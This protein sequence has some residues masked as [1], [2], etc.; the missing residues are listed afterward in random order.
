MENNSKKNSF[1]SALFFAKEVSGISSG[2]EKNHFLNRFNKFTDGIMKSLAYTSARA[3]GFFFLS[4][5]ILSLIM[6]LAKYYFADNPVVELT[7]LIICAAF[8]LVGVPLIFVDKPLSIML[9]DFI[10][11]D[12]IFF[13][14]F[15]IKRM[16][17]D[18]KIKTIP[19]LV[20]IIVG[21]ILAILA[22]LFGVEFVLLVL[23]LLI[24][25]T[26]SFVSAEFPFLFTL[27]ILPY[28]SLFPNPDLSLLG[29]LI[30]TLISFF[31]KVIL[32]KRVYVFGISD[33]LI[34]LFAFCIFMF[35]VIGGGDI[36]NDKNL[37]YFVFS[38]AYIPTANMIVNRRLADCAVEAVLAS[39]TPVALYS[40]IVHILR[41]SGVDSVSYNAIGSGEAVAALLLVAT[42][43]SLFHIPHKKG[44]Q[45]VV[46][47]IELILYLSS[48]LTSTL[49]PVLIILPIFFIAFAIIFRT[50]T[51][52]VWA[53]FLF[54]VPG[55]IFLLPNSVLSSISGI[56]QMNLTL[57]EMRQQL[58]SLVEIFFENIF[59]GYDYSHDASIIF[60]NTPI[61]IGLRFGI[62]AVVII[63]LILLLRL[64][65]FSLYDS[66]LR[67][68]SSLLRLSNMTFLAMMSLLM[69]GW[70]ND[71]SADLSIYALFSLVFGMSTASLRISK[72][73]YEDRQRYFGDNSRVDSSDA[74]I[75]LKNWY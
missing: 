72:N 14:F 13:E 19:N 5:G 64:R 12:Y 1:L 36:L 35:G 2:R 73:E 65:Q 41:L 66:Y 31:R 15:S 54:L 6:N 53:L 50:R 18:E 30:L 7:T 24:F 71:V 62:F 74:D 61:A 28:T 9:Q 10:I 21:L 8:V 38:L 69:L 37:I 57:P 43:F 56:F 26:V 44:A 4:F 59:L 3:I 75:T 29:L 70:F 52:K 48:L 45:K 27:L 47:I 23:G 60:I 55:C 42:A 51:S 58:I 68:S 11:T 67:S 17:R 20:A 16:R 33:V 39:A 25:A 49:L 63:A 40:L 34:F 22:F 32:G 46:A